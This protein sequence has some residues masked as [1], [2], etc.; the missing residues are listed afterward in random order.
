MLTIPSHTSYALQP[1]DVACF[2]PFKVA[3]RAYKHAWNVKSNGCKVKKAHLASWV[4]LTLK[5]ALTSTNIRAG[6]RGVRIWP[7]DIDAM[8]SKMDPSEGF[9]PQ[10]AAEIELEEQ[11]NQKIL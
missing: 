7:L 11:L 2:K 1:L 6:F 9:V 3:F 8:I 4:S 10:S 5:K